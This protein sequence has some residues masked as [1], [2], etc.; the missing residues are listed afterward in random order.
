MAEIPRK[1]KNVRPSW[2]SK[3]G[4]LHP[5][6][7]FQRAGL[8]WG[9]ERR[10]LNRWR[11]LKRLSRPQSQAVVNKWKPQNHHL[12]DSYKILF[13]GTAYTSTTY[14]ILAICY[15]C[16]YIQYNPSYIAYMTR[17][18]NRSSK[19]VV[20]CPKHMEFIIDKLMRWIRSRWPFI[21]TG[22]PTATL[23]WFCGQHTPMCLSNVSI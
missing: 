9:E 14:C 10:S 18:I 21:V 17:S 8:M 19:E 3:N 15:Y 6:H 4:M 5:W 16:F 7:T 2:R 12:R 22:A 20:P 1:E 11:K 13:D 23:Q